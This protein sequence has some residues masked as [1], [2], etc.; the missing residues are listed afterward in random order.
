[1]GGLRTASP[2]ARACAELIN[3]WGFEF[4][5]A[6]RLLNQAGRYL[7]KRGHHTD[8]EPLY[9]QAMAIREKTLGPVHPDL[10]WSLYNLATLYLV[11]RQYKMAE[12]LYERALTI[13]E[14]MDPEHPVV[15]R[16]LTRLAALYRDKGQYLKA[17]S[18]LERALPIWEKTQG[19][20]QRGR[21]GAFTIWELCASSSAKAF[22]GA[23]LE[24][25]FLLV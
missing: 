2:Q 25:V 16:T 4:P 6:S 9:K 12:P 14:K 18:L 13:W 15:A 24:E 1:L 11:R 17:E 20:E 7:S 10:A 19:P 22:R 3:E 8:T 23:S 21:R 5:E